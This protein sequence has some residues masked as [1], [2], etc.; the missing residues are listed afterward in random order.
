MSKRTADAL[1][2]AAGLRPLAWWRSGSTWRAIVLVYAP[3]SLASHFVWEV[4]Q[5]PLYAIWAV[6]TAQEIALATVHCTL[7]DLLIAV[8]ALAIALTV[9]RSG[10]FA[11]WKLPVVAALAIAAEL[12]YTIV[13]ERLN[14]ALGHW[15]YSAAMPMVPVADVGLSPLAQWLVA[16]LATFWFLARV[17]GQ[18]RR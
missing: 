3:F 13:S 15:S 11:E 5:L 4:A 1:T 2:T 9:T 14:I 16:P 10:D 7:G 6:G 12:G 18:T 17:R 8:G